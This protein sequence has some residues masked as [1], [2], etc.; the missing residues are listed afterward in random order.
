L[1]TEE[2][3]LRK[4]RKKE[5]VPKMADILK[6]SK[7]AD[8]YGWIVS[9]WM[10][11]VVGNAQ[12]NKRY[13]REP[14]SDVATGSDEAFLLII[15]E[16]NYER[17]MAEVREMM[18]D[19]KSTE[20]EEEKDAKW[21]AKLPPAKFTNSGT[22]TKTGKAS[23]KRFQGWSKEGYLRFNE[24]HS[25]VKEDRKQRA[26]FE[27]ELKKSFAEEHSNE[28]DADS[29]DSDEEEIFPANDMDV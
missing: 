17:W 15:V 28:N 18:E 13:Y 27:L 3:V 25:Q 14:L 7:N 12:W 2:D 21:R 8:V 29:S 6:L 22:S 5:G 1:L 23:S 11:C 10:R 20:D 9:R 26:N 4:K 24:L 19:K 16:N